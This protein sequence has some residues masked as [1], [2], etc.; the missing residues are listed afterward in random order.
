MSKSIICIHIGYTPDFNDKKTINTYGSEK[1]LICTCSLLTSEYRIIIFGTNIFNEGVFN[2]IEFYSAKKMQKFI[3]ENKIDVLILFRYLYPILEIQLKASKVI[4]WLTDTT[5]IYSYEAMDI[6][7]MGRNLL[8]NLIDKFDHVVTL[9]NWHKNNIIELYDIPENKL[10]VIGSAIDTNNYIKNIV[11]QKNRFIW[12]SNGSRGIRRLFDY[13]ENIRQFMPDAELYVYRDES[14]FIPED[15]QWMH[16]KEYIHYGGK[17]SNDKV[18]EEFQKS[19]YW[20][21]PTDFDETYC[22]SAVEAQLAKCLCITSYKG[23]LIETVADRG[24]L[25]KESIYSDNYEQIALD[26][27]KR[28]SNNKKLRDSF[29]K[30]AHVWA[31]DQ[32]WK[33]RAEEWRKLLK[34]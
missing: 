4:L 29:I 23:A 33:K 21:Y 10:E 15:L 3:D 14:A 34:K 30:K 6:K 24:I 12:T 25:I 16:D 18:F 7:N 31:K 17:I 20:F 2:G 28:L 32:T 22:M 19:Q 9:T 26:N 5:P 13:F 27:L 1:Q 8:R 11:K